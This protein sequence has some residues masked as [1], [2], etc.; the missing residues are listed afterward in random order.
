MQPKVKAYYLKIQMQ[1]VEEEDGLVGVG[2]S[3]SSH[4]RKKLIQEL[5]Q[6]PACNI[7]LQWLWE[8]CPNIVHIQQKIWK[9]GDSCKMFKVGRGGSVTGEW[10]DVI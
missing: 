5:K 2:C 6:A 9:G 10:A 4:Q 7:S 1:C 8:I 3:P